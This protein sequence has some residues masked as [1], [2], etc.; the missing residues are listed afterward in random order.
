MLGWWVQ[1]VALP[2]VGECGLGLLPL[3]LDIFAV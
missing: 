2:D 1:C 3:P